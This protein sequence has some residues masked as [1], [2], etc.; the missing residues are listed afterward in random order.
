MTDLPLLKIFLSSPGDVAEERALAEI[1]FRRLADELAAT[2]RLNLVIWEHEPL[3]GHTGFQQQ[4]ERPSQC[5][6]V[7]CILWS[8]LGTRLPSDFAPAA[9]EA[10]P[11]GTEFELQDA[12]KSF[13]EIG[14]PNLLIYRKIPGPQIGLGSADFTER[15]NQYH[16]LDEFCR[17]AF[18]DADGAVIVAHTT[19]SDSHT[20]ERRLAE[21]GRRWLDREI[22]APHPESF[23]P[24][25]RGRSPYR[26]L[27]SFE[28][29]HQAIFFGRSEALGELMRRIRDTELAAGTGPVT[30]LLLVQGMSGTG[31]T[32]L[33]TA[34]L[35]PL[36][37]L[38]PVEGIARWSTV[39]LRPSESDPA[40]RERG[41][42]GVLASR[43]AECVPA[44]TRLGTTV[45]KLAEMLGARP[46]E[47]TTRIETCVAADADRSGIDP[48]H[49]RILIYVDQLEEAFALPD[50]S[51][52]AGSLFAA[53][54][55]LSRSESVWIAATLRSDFVHRLEAF[56]DLMQCIGRNTPYTLL[57]PR[58]D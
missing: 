30:R 17:H 10:A 48:K 46:E 51:A 12:L 26:G 43:L 20:F 1:V 4:I 37:E 32:S 25:W 28:A 44:I 31:K 35:L 41:A 19:F 13:A 39:F 3:F 24:L 54:V 9:G 8:R 11:T 21:H 7:V 50:A 58:S 52:A 53:L 18:Y 33:F 36:L 57:P 45:R 47:A 29:E 22:Q 6:L 5:D 14:K 40:M 15:S 34:G 38:R 2:V 56:P 23:R 16:R 49:V 55:A 27:Q 42:L